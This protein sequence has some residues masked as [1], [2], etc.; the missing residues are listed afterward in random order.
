MGKLKQKEKQSPVHNLDNVYI[1]SFLPQSVHQV[2][3]QNTALTKDT[4]L[5]HAPK[6]K[7]ITPIY[8]CT[9]P[10]PTNSHQNLSKHLQ[11]ELQQHINKLSSRIE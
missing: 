7:P 2:W 8:A 10:S 5:P 1:T 3:P 9:T 4:D 6:Q 11:G